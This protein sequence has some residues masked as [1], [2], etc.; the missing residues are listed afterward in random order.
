MPIFKKLEFEGEYLNGKKYNGKLT[1]YFN[2]E[3][4]FDGVYINGKRKKN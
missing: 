4:I 3:L 1:E 2:N